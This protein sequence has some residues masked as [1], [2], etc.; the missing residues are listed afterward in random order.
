MR[1]YYES[2]GKEDNIGNEAFRWARAK[3][4]KSNKTSCTLPLVGPLRLAAPPVVI[5]LCI[6]SRYLA[7]VQVMTLM[8]VVLGRVFLGVL[9]ARADAIP[10][11]MRTF[12][13]EGETSCWTKLR[14][15]C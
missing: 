4:F 10:R 15:V 8:E 5:C 3:A 9:H 14:V 11:A 6:V 2:M 12:P 13:R 1:S 7:R